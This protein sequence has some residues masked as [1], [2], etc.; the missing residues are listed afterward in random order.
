MRTTQTLFD[1]N[2][3]L[4]LSKGLINQS[5]IQELNKNI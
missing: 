5:D 3:V 4:D 2:S 1:G